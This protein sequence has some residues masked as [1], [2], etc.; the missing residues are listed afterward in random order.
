MSIVELRDV[1]KMYHMGEV[2][3]PVLR[4]IDLTIKKGEF[5]SI[6]G[7]SGSG[8][9]TL[10]HMIGALDRPTR[11]KV[12]V[13]GKEISK[14]DDNELATLRGR[15][16]G[17]I[18]QSFNLIP[19]L[20]AVENVMLPMW[21]SGIDH[22]REKHA[23]GLLKKVGLGHRLNNKPSQLSGGELQRVAIA[24]SLVNSPEV[25]VADEP[26]GELDSKTGNDIIKLLKKI[27]EE[28]K[29]LIMV[30][31]DTKIANTAHRKIHLLDGKITRISGS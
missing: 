17:F 15:T 2:D 1:E 26:T 3:I 25:I 10:L 19:R 20:T 5:V 7:P 22:H 30:T 27:N 31:H 24:R 6:M 13:K 28:G 4:G 21:F 9:S 11:G 29:T 18:F 16:V 12:L 8:K 23:E 14:M